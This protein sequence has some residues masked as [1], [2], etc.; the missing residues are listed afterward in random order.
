MKRRIALIVLVLL[1][2][3]GIYLATFFPPGVSPYMELF[4]KTLN[5]GVRQPFAGGDGECRQ[6]IEPQP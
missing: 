6:G 2:L 5:F 4:N 1:L 3:G